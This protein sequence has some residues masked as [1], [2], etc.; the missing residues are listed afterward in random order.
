MRREVKSCILLVMAIAIISGCLFTSGPVNAAVGE[1][2]VGDV[3]SDGSVS[4]TD[5]IIVKKIFSGKS[6]SA[7]ITENADINN[8][9][10]VTTNDYAI[11]KRIFQGIPVQV[12]PKALEPQPEIEDEGKAFSYT[13][14][15]TFSSHM[16]IQRYEYIT[17]Y[18][19]GSQSGGVIY[20]KLGDEI[21]YGVVDN[22]GNWSVTLNGRKE[23][24]TGQTMKVYTKAQGE[25]GGIILSDIL[26]GDVWII[27]GQSN[28]QLSLNSTIVNN[29]SFV[30]KISESDNIRLFTQWFWNCT[31][32]FDE[33]F[34]Q[35]NGVYTVSDP[36]PQTETA[37]GTKWLVANKDNALGFSAVGYYFAKRVSDFT[38]VPIGMIQC[39]A[40]GADLC[41]FMPPD[42]YDSS[43]HTKG[44]S[45]FSACDIYN[46]LISPF[47]KTEI[48]GMLFYQ[49]EGN[50]SAYS[51][52]AEDLADFIGMMRDIYGSDMPFYNVQLPSH[53]TGS[54]WPGLANVRFAQFDVLNMVDNY[55][56]VSTIDKAISSYDTDWAHPTNKKFIGDRLANIALAKIYAYKDFPINYYSSPEFTKVTVKDQYAYIYFANYGDG[57]KATSSGKVYGF[58]D[59]NTGASLSA[60]IEGANCVKVKISSRVTKIAYG[61]SAMA[62]SATC[63]LKNSNNLPALAFTCDL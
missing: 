39:V 46:C 10:R 32:Y 52:Y 56:L 44:N 23:N 37:P 1:K 19:T 55:Y 43:M 34:P 20:V 48:K 41:D 22:N 53:N 38:D 2:V 14:S 13:L 4:T 54:Y 51:A 61:N 8:D 30:N 33:D 18:G 5:Y 25:N 62:T 58:T 36:E 49:G 50:E 17:V 6:F 35:K 27:A 60:T 42:K 57:L 45:Q 40:G 31:N 28:A 16:V 11:I 15:S 26:I 24:T 12:L 63:N 59:Y 7:E 3:N 29:Q 47:A 9:G 21:R